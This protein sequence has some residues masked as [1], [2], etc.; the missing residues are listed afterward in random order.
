M[1]LLNE[2]GNYYPEQTVRKDCFYV[3]DNT[4]RTVA[5]DKG[6]QQESPIGFLGAVTANGWI[7]LIDAAFGIWYHPATTE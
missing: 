7:L 5:K 4:V 3:K 6:R 2:S 1:T